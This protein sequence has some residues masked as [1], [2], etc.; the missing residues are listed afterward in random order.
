M[1]FQMCIRFL[2]APLTRG[3]G[4]WSNKSLYGICVSYAVSKST[5][6][7]T[8]TLHV[9]AAAFQI[10]F[11]VITH[12]GPKNVQNRILNVGLPQILLVKFDD[13]RHLFFLLRINQSISWDFHYKLSKFMIKFEIIVGLG[14]ECWP[15]SGP[16]NT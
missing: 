7:K 13:K 15:S 5:I 11:K 2:L 6:R 14:V 9:S 8:A 16:K 3:H 1:L 4:C 10:G 12:I